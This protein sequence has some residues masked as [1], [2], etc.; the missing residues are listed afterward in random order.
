MDLWPENKNIIKK[1]FS[2]NAID[3]EIKIFFLD[4]PSVHS[5]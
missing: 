1:F 2:A 4:V 5:Y 3:S